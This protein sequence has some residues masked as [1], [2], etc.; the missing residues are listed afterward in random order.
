[1]ESNFINNGLFI[2]I[3]IFTLHNPLA[4]HVFA[5][6]EDAKATSTFMPVLYIFGDSIVDSG[7]N[8]YLF[9]IAKSNYLPYG[10]DFDTHKP[11]G[12]FSNGRLVP[13]FLASYMGVPFPSPYLAPDTDIHQ[14][15]NFASAGSGYLTSTGEAMGILSFPKQVQNFQAMK[16]RLQQSMGEASANDFISRSIMYISMA[17]NDI[18]NNYYASG[19]PFRRQNMTIDQFENML[20]DEVSKYIQVL[21]NE[22]A[23]K[24]V[25]ESLLPLGCAPAF[26]KASSTCVDYL[27]EAAM[28][29]NS[30]LQMLLE[31]QSTTFTNAHFIL[32]NGFDLI[33]AIAHDPVGYGFVGISQ[34]CCGQGGFCE[35]GSPTCQ[36]ASTYVFWDAFHPTSKIYSML[37]SRYWGGK[38]SEISP[39]NI[40]QL[41]AL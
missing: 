41:V 6:L 16:Q 37:A 26:S 39:I 35:S 30:L 8:N 5:A 24:F 3:C 31:K 25:F 28:K 29:Y 10:K 40:S 15:A 36:N 9:T 20:I 21:Y 13:D 17:H 27:V 38:T 32:A 7:N 19:S 18:A 12:R 1:M 4:S 14:G 23:R 34:A 11:T 33:N 22:G 2:T